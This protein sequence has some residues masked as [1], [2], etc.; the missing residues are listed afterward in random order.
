MNYVKITP[1]KDIDT[2]MCWR[3][4]VIAAVFGEDMSGP[5][6]S[7]NYEYYRTH[8]SAGSHYAVIA[9]YDG[10]EAG[11]GGVC[12]SDELP[13]PDNPSGRCGYLMNI[14]VREPFRRKGV[15]RAIVRVLVEKATFEGCGKIYL[16][17]TDT[18]AALYKNAGFEDMYG[19]MKFEP[20]NSDSFCHT[21]DNP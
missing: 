12:F 19:M 7:E 16:E 18:A 20:N 15:G 4:E 2:L 3:K 5:L 11:C 17:T 8:I 13:S 21:P 14:Y 10:C 6:L 1:V 9:H